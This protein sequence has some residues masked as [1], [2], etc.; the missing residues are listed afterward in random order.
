MLPGGLQEKLQGPQSLPLAKLRNSRCAFPRA[1][2]V[3]ENNPVDFADELVGDARVRESQPLTRRSRAIAAAYALA[4]VVA[5]SAIA[6]VVPWERSPEPWLVAGLVAMFAVFSRVRFEVGNVAAVPDVLV[7]VPILFLAPLPLVP[8]L[9]AAGFLLASVPDW[10]AGRTHPDRWVYA[11]SDASFSLGPVL[12]VGLLAPGE[13]HFESADVYVLAFAAQI[14]ATLIFQGTR[15]RVEHGVPM[16]NSIQ[17]LAFAH[18][19]DAIMWPVGLMAAVVATEEPLSLLAL[20]PLV[21]LLSVFSRERSERYAAAL[22]LNRAY[23]GTV[24]LLSDVVEADDH[25]TA[26]HCRSVVELVNAVADELDVDSDQRQEL[27]FAALLHDVGKIAIPKEIINKPA[28]LTDDEFELVK[29]HTIEGQVLLNRVGGLL[30]RVGQIVRSCHERWDGQGYPDGLSGHDI[31]LA[32]RIVFCCDAYSAMTTDRPY[33]AAMS[34]E[35]ALTELWA[36]AGTQFDPRVVAALSNVI[37]HGFDTGADFAMDEVRAVLA[38]RDVS[39][40]ASR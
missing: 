7:F 19:I 28:A 30:A 24:M 20:G 2:P 33:R 36:N 22:E 14:L 1:R 10:L 25:Y 4:F 39:R 16:M 37:R 5:A 17:S 13:A 8:A 11:L 31:P 35:T 23:R 3:A 32:A 38:S 6:A 21:W 18:R 26:D 12:V 40:T 29:T 9:V 27:E 15:E 34:R